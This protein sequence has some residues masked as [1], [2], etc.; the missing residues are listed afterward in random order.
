MKTII[1]FSILFS[2]MM[3]GQEKNEFA[4]IYFSS[5]CCGT[6]SE[7]KLVSFL[8]NFKTQH[9]IKNIF[10]YNICCLGEEG[11]YSIIIDMRNFSSNEKIKLK[12]GLKKTQLAYNEVYKKSAEGSIIITYIDDLEAVSHQKKIGKRQILEL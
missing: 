7:E 5:K 10:V 8:K 4:D 9:K 3:F 2:Y 12:E 11:E 6:P 1:L